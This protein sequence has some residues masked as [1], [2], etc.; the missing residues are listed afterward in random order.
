MDHESLMARAARHFFARAQREAE[1][2][3]L[4]TRRSSGKKNKV[5]QWVHRVTSHHRTSLP[6]N[7][8]HLKRRE[9]F[10]STWLVTPCVS[11]CRTFWT[12]PRSARP[13]PVHTAKS[14]SSLHA[15]LPAVGLSSSTLCT[16]HGAYG[17]C[18]G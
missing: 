12:V 17:M 18:Y 3:N 6:A 15:R 7:A 10:L 5:S 2:Q 9:V 13:V 8:V 14:C 11:V 1:R 16:P 4:P